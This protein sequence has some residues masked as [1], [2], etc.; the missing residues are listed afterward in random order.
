MH[1]EGRKGTEGQEISPPYWIAKC[2]K[3]TVQTDYLLDHLF[4]YFGESILMIL[5]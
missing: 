1:W 3:K 2:K 4:I 5:L